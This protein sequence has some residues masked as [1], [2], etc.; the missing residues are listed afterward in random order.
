M[1]SRRAAP[2][3]FRDGPGARKTQLRGWPAHIVV[4][5]VDYW[6]L[7]PR[8]RRA[9]FAHMARGKVANIGARL[10]VARK[11]AGLTQEDLASAVGL[12]RTAV[13]KIEA[14]VR[15]LDALELARIAE[16][17]EQLKAGRRPAPH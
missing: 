17:V 3:L 16:M 15:S 13:T 7:V 6:Y 8:R 11:A 1:K 2:R 14:G 4:I 5:I 10:A 9:T 12:D